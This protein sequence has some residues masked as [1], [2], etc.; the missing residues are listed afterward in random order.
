MAIQPGCYIARSMPVQA[1]SSQFCQVN[2]KFQHSEFQQMLNIW[3]STFSELWAL[4]MFSRLEGLWWNLFSMQ[5]VGPCLPRFISTVF[6]IKSR[7]EAI[8]FFFSFFSFFFSSFFLISSPFPSPPP[9]FFFFSFSFYFFSPFP[10][11]LCCEITIIYSFLKWGLCSAVSY[12]IYS[13]C[14]GVTVASCFAD[15]YFLQHFKLAAITLVF[16]QNHNRNANFSQIWNFKTLGILCHISCRYL[17]SFWDIWDVV[18]PTE[19]LFWDYSHCMLFVIYGF[20]TGFL[21]MIWKNTTFIWDFSEW[22][23]CL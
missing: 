3:L 23:K 21:N 10:N 5:A 12:D 2:A 16:G 20:F 7:I 22:K 18:F 4:Q 14:N 17:S 19:G 8:L 13:V 1:M 6:G 15:L 9:F 11:T